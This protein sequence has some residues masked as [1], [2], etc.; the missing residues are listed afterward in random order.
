MKSLHEKSK[1]VECSNPFLNDH[2]GVSLRRNKKWQQAEETLSKCL[3]LIRSHPLHASRF[4][5]MQ[6]G[7]DAEA[8]NI[9]ALSSGRAVHDEG[10]SDTKRTSFVFA[11]ALCLQNLALVQWHKQKEFERAGE[12]V[13]HAVLK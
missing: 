1:M 5:Q 12:S 2:S 8:V 6:N 11:E 13:S 7:Q 9:S 4:L 3:Q 10:M